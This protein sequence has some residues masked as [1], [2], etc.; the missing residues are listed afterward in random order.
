MTLSTGRRRWLLLP[1]I[2]LAA[3]C[4]DLEALQRGGQPPSQ[5][6]ADA[7]PP[8]DLAALP[9]AACKSG[10]G[11]PMTERAVAC[12]ANLSRPGDITAACGSGWSLCETIPTTPEGCAGL[13]GGF[14]ASSQRGSQLHVPPGP[15]LA[16]TWSGPRAD[17][18]QRF[19]FGCG[20]AGVKTLYESPMPCGGFG[21]TLLCRN[22]SA[23]AATTWDCLIGSRP[24]DSDF[25]DVT[26]TDGTGGVLCCR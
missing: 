12:Q 1:I 20:G 8:A 25:A 22:G 17:V 4:L 13:S 15:S 11:T 19:L 7:A 3:A 24:G 6:P 23:E 21:R 16:C 26:N 18:D 2:G 10:R 5:A 9:M 14:Y